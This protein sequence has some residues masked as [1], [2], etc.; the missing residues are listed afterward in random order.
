MKLLLPLVALLCC[1]CVSYSDMYGNKYTSV[2]GDADVTFPGGGHMTHSHTA[3]FQHMMQGAT[4]L[5]GAGIT[6]WGAQAAKA[7]D[8]AVTA[9]KNASDASLALQAEKDAAAAASQTSK[10]NFIQGLTTS[11]GHAPGH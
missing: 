9:A 3:S 11:L 8:D 1:S 7:S 6:A 4:T 5:G 10:Q 2:G